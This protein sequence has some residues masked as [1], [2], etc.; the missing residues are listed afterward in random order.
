MRSRGNDS[1]IA[2]IQLPTQYYE[3]K[4]MRESVLAKDTE[5]KISSFRSP[6][7]L[8]RLRQDP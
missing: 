1:I 7:S 6:E 2:G 8:G 3:K 5:M 4:T